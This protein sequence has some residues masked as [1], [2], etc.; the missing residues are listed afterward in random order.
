MSSLLL[1]ICFYDDAHKTI[2]VD[3]EM[4]AREVVE[5]ISD[6]L[7]LSEE[8]MNDFKVFEVSASGERSLADDEI[9]YILQQKWDLEARQ[10]KKKDK[11]EKP[12][13]YFKRLFFM[14]PACE[15]LDQDPVL[16]HLLYTQSRASILAGT[17]RV[18]EEL[19]L[20]LAALTVGEAFGVHDPTVH[21]PGFLKSHLSEFIP[22]WL[23]SRKGRSSSDWER[24]IFKI[25]A[26]LE[27]VTTEEVEDRYIAKV[28]SLPAYGMVSFPAKYLSR[29]KS[30]V[31]VA[32]RLGVSQRGLHLLHPETMRPRGYYC[33]NGL[34]DWTAQGPLFLVTTDEVRQGINHRFE[35]TPGDSSELSTV[36][37]G[38]VNRIMSS[39]EEQEKSK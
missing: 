21:R 19:L 34:I 6:K 20:E 13:F 38:Y 10:R 27:D 8:V 16:K 35:M 22:G 24:E 23:L 3:K 37:R 7:E 11:T 12:K 28:R 2:T 17:F 32:I 29:D 26:T 30:K 14:N 9:P 1:K 31:G 36:I 4:D 39:V 18:P 15:D 5:I 33:F 25:H